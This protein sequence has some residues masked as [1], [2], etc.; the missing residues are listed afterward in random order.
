MTAAASYP[1]VPRPNVEKL[2]VVGLQPFVN[3]VADVINGLVQSGAISGGGPGTWNGQLK[4][5]E[6]ITGGNPTSILWVDING[7]LGQDNALLWD[8]GL[9]ELTIGG[10]KITNNAGGSGGFFMGFQ[11][12][13]DNTIP[14]FDFQ[15]GPGTTAS[16]ILSITGDTTGTVPLFQFQTITATTLFFIDG[17]GNVTIEN[18]GTLTINGGAGT[19]LTVINTTTAQDIFSVSAFAVNAA[20]G[21][22]VGSDIAGNGLAL[23]VTSSAGNENLRINAKGTGTI[24]IGGV[25]TGN[26]LVTDA[27]VV[28]SSSANAFAVGRQGTTNPAFQINANTASC[29]TGILG[30]AKAAGSGFTIAAT[31]SGTNENLSLDAKGS[32]TLN[33]N[34]TATGGVTIG[35]GLTVSA[36]GITV[37]SGN[38][39]VSSGNLTVS[40]TGTITSS[41]ATAL[42]VG[43]QGSTN[44]VLTCDAS[45][46]SVVTGAKLKGA[47]S[48][49]GFALS[50]TSSASNENFTIDALGTG[51]VQIAN[52]STGLVTIRG[53]SDK[54]LTADFTHTGDTSATNITGMSFAI[55][56]NEVWDVEF[57]VLCS[58]GTNGVQLSVSGPSSP[59]NTRYWMEGNPSGGT[60]NNIQFLNQANQGVSLGTVGQGGNS[61]ATI[62]G[63]IENGANAGTVQ[64]VGTLVNGADTMT[65]TRGTYM[66][67][68]RIS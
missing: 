67:A 65:I 46:A 44:P 6:T 33:L 48:G 2:G 51:G 3:E 41:S 13:A 56:A 42:T 30:T 43:R 31:S 45:T 29:V 23:S 24:T 17:A 9:Q 55:A 20:T 39:A 8:T 7:D 15:L 53:Y 38:V 22:Q 16:V 21:L 50:V 52:T 68:R 54:C 25:S 34:V 14:A 11:G 27:L 57:C 49:A 18:G 5:G 28:T 59:T 12:A 4:I 36:S 1:P 58:G 19:L 61:I 32:G 35:H 62:R 10:P 60:G 63:V 26:V 40:G 37:T 66:R 47:A 64:L